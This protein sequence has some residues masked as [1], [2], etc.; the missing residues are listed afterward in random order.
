MHACIQQSTKSQLDWI[1]LVYF[2]LLD[3]VDAAVKLKTWQSTKS[4]TSKTP[5]NK[6]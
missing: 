1:L 4:G 5:L 2:Q 3:Q 6:H